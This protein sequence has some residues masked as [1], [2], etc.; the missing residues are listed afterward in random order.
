MKPDVVVK[1]ETSET[2]TDINKD[3]TTKPK[4]VAKV[5]T[6]ESEADMIAADV[7]A[8]KALP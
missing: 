8:A 7:I 5:E 1:I 6:S 3:K 2:Q 4:F